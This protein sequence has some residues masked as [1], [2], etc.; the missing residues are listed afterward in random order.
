MKNT[1]KILDYSDDGVLD[2]M[3]DRAAFKT[4]EFIRSMG[5]TTTIEE[6]RSG[7]GLNTKAL[8]EHIDHLLQHELV[9]LVR[10]RKP[11]KSIGYRSLVDRL[12]ISFDEDDE[13]ITQDLIAFSEETR[14]KY[15]ANV[16]QHA[17]PDFN[18]EFGFRFQL[19]E[20]VH[21][22]EDEFA[23]LKRRMLS[24]VSFLTMPRHRKTQTNDDADGS[25]IEKRCCNQ[26][27]K[28]EL[29]PLI[30]D[31][32]P[33]ASMIMSPRSQLWQWDNEKIHSGGMSTLS[34]REREVVMGLAD[35]LSRA[36]IADRMEVSVNT[37]ST[38][39]QRSYKKIGVTSQAQLAAR[40]SGHAREKLAES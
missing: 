21:F 28:I 40:I 11:R 17:D 22:T 6:I 10:A 24:V 7:T 30:G 35:G 34:P 39:T 32:L 37:V 31:L 29:V 27:I 5:R 20:T 23:E 18:P 14:E 38:L 3:R 2:L 13:S 9:K 16:K 1:T 19:R 26:A 15:D 4:W 36:Q 33:N 25:E 8:H 12:V